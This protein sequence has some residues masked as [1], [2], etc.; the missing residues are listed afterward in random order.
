MFRALGDLHIAALK[1][2]G[3]IINHIEGGH[4]ILMKEGIR[5]HQKKREL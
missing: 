5:L 1:R 3:W 2:T 4:S